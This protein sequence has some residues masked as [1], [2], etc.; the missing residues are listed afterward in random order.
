MQKDIYF[1]PP[2]LWILAFYKSSDE[3]LNH[4]QAALYDITK[5]I[6]AGASVHYHKNTH[7]TLFWALT[8]MFSHSVRSAGRSTH[9]HFHYFS[10]CNLIQGDIQWEAWGPA[11]SQE[12]K[13]LKSQSSLCLT[14]QE[15]LPERQRE[16]HRVRAESMSRTSFAK[17]FLCFWMFGISTWEKMVTFFNFTNNGLK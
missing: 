11:Y 7:C 5:T 9:T 17:C 12:I 3:S 6:K 14:T 16:T 8:G 10:A 1:F 13:F 15:S 4:K 2:N